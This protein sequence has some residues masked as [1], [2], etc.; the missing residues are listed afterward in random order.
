M[1]VQPYSWPLDELL[2][3][4]ISS[5]EA[6]RETGR[7]TTDKREDGLC[8][9]QSETSAQIASVSVHGVNLDSR[10]VSVGDV[11]LAVSGHSTHG[12]KF[13]I[14]AVDRGAV[15]VVTSTA[16]QEQHADI[17]EMLAARDVPV[18]FMSSIEEY[19][20]QIAARFYGEP[21]ATLS[22][23]AVTGTDGKTSVCQFISQAMSDSGTVCGYIGTL[24]WGMPGKLNDTSLTTPDSVSLRRMLAVMRDQGARCV[25][26]EAS[27]HGIAEGRLDGLAI[28]VAVLTN[29]GRDHLDYHGTLEAYRAAKEQLFHWSTLSAVVLNADDAMGQDLI[30]E[31]T[32]VRQ[33]NYSACGD[34]K[35]TPANTVTA[36]SIEA[37]D[38]GLVFCL[39]D[40]DEKHLL[41]TSLLGRFNVDNLLASYACMRASGIAA[42]EARHALEHVSPVAGRMQ[43][44]GGHNKPTVVIDYSHTPG[45]LST[46]I[47]AVRIHCQRELWVVFGCGGDRDTGKRAPMAKAAEAAE[48]VVVTNDN[49]R[50]EDADSIIKDV[51]EGF[52]DKNRVLV[53]PDRSEAIE[54]AVLNAH[55]DDLILIAGKGHENYQVIGTERHHFSDLE[56]AQAAL[57]KTS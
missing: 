22:I 47:D 9:N 5:P 52:D 26:L 14:S 7:A 49:P 56:H 23:V 31:L 43:R 3:P 1:N 37:T 34:V 40:E 55:S 44:L 17:L 28:D 50:T 4:W 45:A 6:D 13:A 38:Q 32:Q 57:E 54:H 39:V 27:S 36:S 30:S 33:L 42:N 12:I 19:C 15:A 51:L 29:L 25:A 48:Y 41:Q 21:D 46:A 20:A 11:Y 35:S 8:A 53:I 18:V 2:Q 10:L 24:G 16:T